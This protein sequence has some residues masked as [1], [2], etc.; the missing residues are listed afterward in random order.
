[1]RARTEPAV[2]RP[3]FFALSCIV[4]AVAAF[5]AARYLYWKG[6]RSL[7]FVPKVGEHLLQLALVILA[8]AAVKELIQW[9]DRLKADHARKIQLQHEF[10]TRLRSAHVSVRRSRDLMRAHNSARTWAEQSRSIIDQI[11]DLEELAEELK[12]AD[13]LFDRYHSD[14]ISGVEGMISYLGG[15]RDEYIARH[16]DVDADWNAAVEAN[17]PTGDRLARTVQERRMTWIRDFMGGSGTF[18]TGYDANVRRAKLPMR[19]VVLGERATAL[20]SADPVI[21]TRPKAASLA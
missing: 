16:R 11:P 5:L 19:L 9:R 8:G 6:G 3:I 15:G 18:L 12:A 13:G 10:L 1:M 4:L 21:A 2:I 20:P 14:I 17:A 7:D